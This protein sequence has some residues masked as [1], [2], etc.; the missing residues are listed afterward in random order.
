MY[1]RYVIILAVIMGIIVALIPHII[2]FITLIIGKIAG[3]R[4]HYAAFGW[5]ALALVGIVWSLLAYG[6]FVGMWR[7]EVN[8]VT[9][10][11]ADVPKGFDDYRIVH[12]SDLHVDTFDERPEALKA[13]VDR[14]NKLDADVIL[15]TGDMQSVGMQAVC[16][17]AST[18]QQLHAR[19]GVKSVLGNHDFFLYDLDLKSDAQRCA[20]ADTLAQY[21]SDHLGWHVLRNTSERLYRNGDSIAIAGVDNI[22]GNQGFATI[23]KGDL[24]KALQGTEGLFT[25]LLSHDPSH[26]RAEV[27]P[28]SD[29]QIT[30]SGHTHA[31]QIRLF[32]KSLAQVSFNECDGRYD[33]DGRMLYVN[34]G[35]GCTAPFRINC[36]SEITVITLKHQ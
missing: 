23:Q 28:E 30:L 24:K 13:I 14:I 35:I 26:W 33:H 20:A 3:F 22:N 7:S 32:G 5:T 4:V 34:A 21:E 19:D 29:V 27:L 31:A 10:A 9:Y 18:L 17:H 15:F 25:I 11:S 8:E 2:W 16:N 1:W 6:H 36:P 12:I